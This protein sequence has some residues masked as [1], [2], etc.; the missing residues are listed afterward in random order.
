MFIS[1][2]E[3]HEQEELRNSA[4]IQ[5]THTPI[6]RGNLKRNYDHSAIIIE[7]DENFVNFNKCWHITNLSKHL[8]KSCLQCMILLK[9]FV[10]VVSDSCSIFKL[11]NDIIVL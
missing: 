8:S 6:L 11:V 2:D 4:S 9:V 3:C 10:F 1:S 7:R 5:N